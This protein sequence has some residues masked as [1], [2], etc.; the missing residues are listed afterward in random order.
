[1]NMPF[2]GRV[3]KLGGQMI[4]FFSSGRSNYWWN[5]YYRVV[6]EEK[7]RTLV[8]TMVSRITR[9]IVPSFFPRDLSTIDSARIRALR[10]V[11]CI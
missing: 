2:I 6:N 3:E 1:M 5:N 10:E 7:R 9:R 11:R 8:S 4:F